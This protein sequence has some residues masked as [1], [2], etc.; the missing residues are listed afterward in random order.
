MENFVSNTE[1]AVADSKPVVKRDYT[2]HRHSSIR[3]CK[4]CGKFFVLSDS[5]A[6]HFF[7]KYGSL[8]LRCEDC[9]RKARERNPWPN[10]V[11]PENS[12]E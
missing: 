7:E 3:V 1:N 8:P 4:D 9:R 5:D 11:A 10:G 12:E 2:L 6:M